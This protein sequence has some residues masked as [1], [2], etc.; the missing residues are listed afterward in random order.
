MF[1]SIISFA[2]CERT[3]Q[4]RLLPFWHYYLAASPRVVPFQFD[5]CIFS[6]AFCIHHFSY[7]PLFFISVSL[8][9]HRRALK[10]FAPIPHAHLIRLT[11][12]IKLE[13]KQIMCDWNDFG[14]GF[15]GRPCVRFGVLAV[16]CTVAGSGKRPS[17]WPVRMRRVR[18]NNE[19]CMYE[20]YFYERVQNICIT[21][22][23]P[24][25]LIQTI[26]FRFSLFE[27]GP[28]RRGCAEKCAFDC[29]IWLLCFA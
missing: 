8:F 24:F 13:R 28:S 12:R 18:T 16:H 11:K 10:I 22:F 7:S 17:C 9:L 25:A 2:R 14:G 19:E 5:Y 15:C 26:D 21:T 20:I 27:I 4:E 3:E 6:F 23:W 1:F 29:S